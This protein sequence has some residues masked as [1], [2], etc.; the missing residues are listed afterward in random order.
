LKYAE[1]RVYLPAELR[2]LGERLGGQ[3]TVTAQFII[4]RKQAMLT[5]L[6]SGDYAE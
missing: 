5:P 1:R 6:L 3:I 2:E 4:C